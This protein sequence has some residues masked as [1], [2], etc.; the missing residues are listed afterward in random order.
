MASSER[1][2]GLYVVALATGM[3]QSELLG[4]QWADV[5]LDAGLIRVRVQLKREDGMW[6]WK[7]PKTRRS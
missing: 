1:L 6:K 4:L 5:D 3:R 2:E 7:E